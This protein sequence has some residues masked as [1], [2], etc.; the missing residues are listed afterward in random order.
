MRYLIVLIAC[1][2]MSGCAG[3]GLLAGSSG[4]TATTASTA[5]S[6]ASTLPS[7]SV[8]D[9]VGKSRVKLAFVN[10]AALLDGSNWTYAKIVEEQCAFSNPDPPFFIPNENTN[11]GWT[12]A[13][14]LNK[15]DTFQVLTYKNILTLGLMEGTD[16]LGTWPVKLIT[17]SDFPQEYLNER[18]AFVN[19][20]QL[21]S[22]EQHELVSKYMA[23]SQQLEARV[24]Q[25]ERSYDPQEQCPHDKK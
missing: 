20:N 18:L 8:F 4:S 1:A 7:P 5:A 10:P 23:D 11:G 24:A 16:Q 25:L 9:Y 22:S 13:G 3:A 6:T 15:D 19:A 14:R 21:G 2:L 17:L 12:F